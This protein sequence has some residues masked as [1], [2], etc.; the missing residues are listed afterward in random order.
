MGLACAVAA[1]KLWSEVSRAN[2]GDG[3]WGRLS[4]A[5]QKATPLC[6]PIH[7]VTTVEGT[8]GLPEPV[9]GDHAGY[10]ETCN[11]Y[12]FRPQLVAP[13]ELTRAPRPW[14]TLNKQPRVEDA[15]PRA[16]AKVVAHMVEGFVR[17]V[18]ARTGRT[19]PKRRPNSAP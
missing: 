19:P 6:P 16:G 13:G 18:C 8:Q 9:G 12:G 10:W 4:P 1:Q 14:Y 11:I 2:A 7:V 15:T 3:W 5:E 17:L